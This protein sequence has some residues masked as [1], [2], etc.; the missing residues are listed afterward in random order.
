M[1]TFL[2]YRPR[3]IRTVMLWVKTRN[4]IVRVHSRYRFWNVMLCSVKN[5]PNKWFGFDGNAFFDNL[6]FGDAASSV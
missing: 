6:K 5:S 2:T 3:S 1:F 4:M